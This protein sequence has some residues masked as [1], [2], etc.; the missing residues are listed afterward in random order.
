MVSREPP[1]SAA[2]FLGLSLKSASF[3]ARTDGCCPKKSSFSFFLKWDFNCIFLVNCFEI[4]NLSR[5]EFCIF[6]RDVQFFWIFI[7][8]QKQMLKD[9]KSTIEVLFWWMITCQRKIKNQIWHCYESP[10]FKNVQIWEKVQSRRWRNMWFKDILE[11]S[12]SLQFFKKFKT[13][14]KQWVNMFRKINKLIYKV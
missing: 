4:L 12:K 2:P 1:A 13:I 7:L 10:I 5:T 6:E 8:E 11:I 14:S 3:A 9:W